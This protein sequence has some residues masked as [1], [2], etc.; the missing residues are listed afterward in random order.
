[1]GN[2]GKFKSH[3]APMR[4]FRRSP[5]A[6]PINSA[7]CAVSD[8][9]GAQPVWE[10]CTGSDCTSHDCQQLHSACILRLS[11]IGSPKLHRPC[12]RRT[13]RTRARPGR[14]CWPEYRS[15][16]PLP[17]QRPQTLVALPS[18]LRHPIDWLDAETI[19]RG[20]PTNVSVLTRAKPFQS[21][22]CECG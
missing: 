18:S 4:S 13:P 5:L 16:R 9:S 11:D 6:E 21:L 12:Q 7:A 22:N 3:I 10:Q 20:H 17:K 19:T 14:L 2:S 15:T 1:L 8:A